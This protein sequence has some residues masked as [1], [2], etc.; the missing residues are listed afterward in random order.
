MRFSATRFQETVDPEAQGKNENGLSWQMNGYQIFVVTFLIIPLS[1][2]LARKYYFLPRRIFKKGDLVDLL[3][4]YGFGLMVLIWGF[5]AF[6]R[7]YLA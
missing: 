1:L 2:M 5:V 4:S 6:Y 3:F 7:R